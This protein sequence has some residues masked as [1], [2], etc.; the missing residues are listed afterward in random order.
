MF[1]GVCLHVASLRNRVNV[2]LEKKLLWVQL[3]SHS[4][5]RAQSVFVF[6][7]CHTNSQQVIAVARVRR[8][9]AVGLSSSR[10]GGSGE[11]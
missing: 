3:Y 4:S 7:C 11:Q 5:F 9:G 8:D 1:L 6:C 2:S 10:Y